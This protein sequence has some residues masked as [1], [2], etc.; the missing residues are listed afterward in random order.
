MNVSLFARR[1]LNFL[2]A[3]LVGASAW[4]SPMLAQQ[5]DH[6]HPM[7]TQGPQTPEQKK[8]ANE[9]ISIVRS[10]TAGFQTPDTLPEGY[11]L[12]FGCVSG[13]SNEGA[14][15]LHYVNTSLVFDGGELDPYTPEIVLY[16][17][18]PNG[19]LKITGADYVVI[20]E[21]WDAKHPNDPP[22]LFGQ[23]FHLIGFPNRFGLKAFYTLHVWAWKD[24]P[25]G[26]FTNWNPTV[27]CEGFN[28]KH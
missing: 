6:Q 7:T 8:Q 13:D 22:K 28:G 3:A 12:L 11:G 10:V 26:A 18:Q 27:T 15:G 17:P 25:N 16:E 1:I 23:L 20:A 14:M 4:P 19:K 2:M 21:D 24:N 5:N 9:L